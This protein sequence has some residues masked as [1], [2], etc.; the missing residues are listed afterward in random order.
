MYVYTLYDVAPSTA[1]QLRSTPPVA[2][3]VGL[4]PRTAASWAEFVGSFTMKNW[5]MGLAN[6]LP[7][8]PMYC[9]Q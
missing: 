8:S 7:S 9:T 2:L 3:M 6:F 4:T 1:C 5:T